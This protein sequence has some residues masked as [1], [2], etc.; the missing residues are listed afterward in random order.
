MSS[1]KAKRHIHKYRKVE[2]N[3]VK[4]WACA[5]PTCSH[6]MPKHYE[7]MVLGKMS[8]CWGCGNEFILDERAMLQD[9]PEC[10]NCAKGIT[11]KDNEVIKDFNIDEYLADIQRK[12]EANK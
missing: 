9:M 5:L 8:I 12:V 1:T 2:V 7:N 11:Q 3:N 10:Y 4:V 6:H